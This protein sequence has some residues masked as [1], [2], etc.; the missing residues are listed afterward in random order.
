MG[1][2]VKLEFIDTLNEQFGLDLTDRD[3]RDNDIES[4]IEDKA[5]VMSN[6]GN[7]M[8]KGMSADGI[9]KMFIH[10]AWIMTADSSWTEE[11]LKTRIGEDFIRIINEENSYRDLTDQF[12]S[13]F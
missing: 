5:N 4:L 9:R 13:L 6:I 11:R 1:K 7:L 10:G 12:V 2:T 8:D 3:I